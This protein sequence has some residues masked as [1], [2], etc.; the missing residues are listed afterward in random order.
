MKR[1][2]YAF[3]MSLAISGQTFAQDSDF[4]KPQQN[5]AFQVNGLSYLEVFGRYT[6]PVQVGYPV[7]TIDQII[8]EIKATGTNLVKITIGVGQ[9]KNYTDNAYDPTRPF[10][11]EGKSSDILAFGH[12]LTSQ[13]IPCYMQPFS[14]VENI[15]AGATVDTSRVNPTDRRAFMTQHI[16]R[17]VS[18]AQLAEGMGCEYFGI[19][20]DEIEQL[21][22][23]SQSHRSV[24]ASNHSGAGSFQWQTDVYLILG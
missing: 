3:F 16:P 19:F 10:P 4:L 18:L 5:G 15:I 7:P 12:K 8:P 1:L 11:L 24:G 9:V 14:S 6:D 20:G 17:L 23:R 22:V 13:G 21:V 2:L